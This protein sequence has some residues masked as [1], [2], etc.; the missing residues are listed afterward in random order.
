[1]EMLSQPPLLGNTLDPERYPYVYDEYILQRGVCRPAI[2][3]STNEQSKRRLLTF[4]LL[5]A[6]ADCGLASF[7]QACEHK[8]NGN[9]GTENS[10]DAKAAPTRTPHVVASLSLPVPRA[11]HP[12]HKCRVER[13]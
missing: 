9:F 4:G 12:L 13:S 11:A 6:I 8:S 2:C 5:G 3:R 10:H 1:M 7:L